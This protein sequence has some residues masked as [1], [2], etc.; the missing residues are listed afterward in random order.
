MSEG[1]ILENL[2]AELSRLPGIGHKT[3]E[4]LAY[5]LLKASRP[6]ALALAEAIR[7]LKEELRECRLCHNISETERCAIC[8]DETRES[9]VICVVEQP[10][11]LHAIE[12]SGSYR[13]RYFVLGGNFVRVLSELWSPA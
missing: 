3:A 9:G 13:G 6:E 2:I 5:H 1:G 7:R 8:A 11:D 12:Q 10:K 4:R